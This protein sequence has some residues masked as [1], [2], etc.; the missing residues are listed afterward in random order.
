MEDEYMARQANTAVAQPEAPGVTWHGRFSL[1]ERETMIREAAYYRYLQR[2][3]AHGHDL[4]DWLAAES[5]IAFGRSRRQPPDAPEQE[6][7][8]SSV[9]GAAADEAL[10]H[11]VKQHPQKAI[12]RVESVEPIDSPRKE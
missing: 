8:Q 4:E 12:S 9:H 2:G 5:E 1:E 11:I 6:V 7:Q 10:K 3:C